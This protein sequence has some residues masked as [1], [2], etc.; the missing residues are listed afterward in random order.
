M[1]EQH[2]AID[3]DAIDGAILPGRLQDDTSGLVAVSSQ[4]GEALCQLAPLLPIE[5]AGDGLQRQIRGM[6]FQQLEEL[7]R[8]VYDLEAAQN[9]HRYLHHLTS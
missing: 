3:E 6:L 7:R 8:G 1:T 4:A 2:L 9:C 5:R